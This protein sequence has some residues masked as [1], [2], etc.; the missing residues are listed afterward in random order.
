MT[1]SY[2]MEQN[3]LMGKNAGSILLDIPMIS[4]D[5]LEDLK[6]AENN[7]RNKYVKSKDEKVIVTGGAG[8]IGSFLVD[9]LVNDGAHVIVVDDFLQEKIKFKKSINDI[10][11]REGNLK[12]FLLSKSLL[13]SKIIFI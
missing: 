7:S 11:I 5:T 8:L 6:L 2:L 3:T 10:E 13:G 1:R 4:I 9:R 12:T